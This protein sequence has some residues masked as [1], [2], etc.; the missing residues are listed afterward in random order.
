MDI[1]V[2][3]TNKYVL[4]TGGSRGIGKAIALRF[5][6]YGANVILQ[7]IHNKDKAEETAKEISKLN[8]EVLVIQANLSHPD[9][10]S[11]MFDEICNWQKGLDFFISNAASGF[12]RP[13]MQ[14]RIEGWNF[15]MDVNARAFLLCT[16]KAVPLM[17]SRGGGSIVAISSPGSWRVLPDYIAVG[18]SKAALDS[19]VR[20]LAVELAPSNIQ[21]NGIAPGIVATDALTH[22]SSI[23]D[24]NLL[25][26]AAEKTPA[27]R[28]VTPDDVAGLAAFLCTTTAEMIRGQV[29]VQDGGFTLPAQW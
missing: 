9:H 22:F 5:A 12:N 17:Q 28:I 13:G 26:R 23:S 2:D 7:Y 6:Y 18:A 24:P 25:L 20:Y 14:Q 19:L 4:V 11:R 10:I 27:G 8:R 3:F 15:T 1:N 21:V 29:I 16:Q